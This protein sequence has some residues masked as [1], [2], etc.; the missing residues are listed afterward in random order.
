MWRNGTNQ[1]KVGFNHT[2]TSAIE[3]LPGVATF[4]EI[5]EIDGVD[6]V[7]GVAVRVALALD[8]DGDENEVG[9]DFFLGDFSTSLSS[10]CS[11]LLAFLSPS[12]PSYS[13]ST[14]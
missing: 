10:S 1:R 12:L 4:P 9:F 7:D 8:V 13:S 11:S 5:E 14:S 2:T 3:R 6:G